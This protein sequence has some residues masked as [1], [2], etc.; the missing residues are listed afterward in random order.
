MSLPQ[1]SQLTQAIQSPQPSQARAIVY[2]IQH[3]AVL[4][5]RQSDQVLQEQLGIGLSQFRILQV[6]STNPSIQQKQIASLLGQTEA[7]ISRQI[8]LMLGRGLIAIEPGPQ[9]RREHLTVLL[10]KGER[11]LEAGTRVVAQYHEPA[12]ASLKPK[13]QDAL[14]RLLAELHRVMCTVDGIEGLVHISHTDGDF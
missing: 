12:L 11:L 7:S 14:L 2:Y 6:V 5:N 3:L 8:K 1:L 13:E 9:D 4:I 10:P